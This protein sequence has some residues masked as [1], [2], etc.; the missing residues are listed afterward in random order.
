M[1]TATKP[2]PAVA[3]SSRTACLT[4]VL[5]MPTI[6]AFWEELAEL[7]RD[8]NWSHEE[9]L[10]AL[11]QRRVADRESKGT[12]MR[13]RTAHFPQVKTLEDFTLDRL[14][15]LRRDVLAHLAK[16]DVRREGGERDPARSCSTRPATGS[17]G[18]AKPTT[19]AGWRR[20]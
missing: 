1:T 5:K 8:Q 14:P 17:P 6:G 20:S 11:L 4:W 13:I 3:G 10:A 9:Y 2:K 12:T 19:S 16:G 18:L 15:P 7:A